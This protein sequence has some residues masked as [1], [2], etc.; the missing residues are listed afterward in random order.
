MDLSNGFKCF[1]DLLGLKAKFT[2]KWY[3]VVQNISVP[4]DYFHEKCMYV[5]FMDILTICVVDLDVKFDTN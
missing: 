2:L 3:S 5:I 4:K 1:I